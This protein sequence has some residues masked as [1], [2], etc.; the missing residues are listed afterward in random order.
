MKISFAPHRAN[1]Y[2]VFYDFAISRFGLGLKKLHPS[3]LRGAVRNWT[4][5]IFCAQYLH[6]IIERI[7]FD[8]R[9][10]FCL[11]LTK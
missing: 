3:V 8:A 11:S 10:V 1:R 9:L 6:Q 5:I 2:G 4:S 7:K